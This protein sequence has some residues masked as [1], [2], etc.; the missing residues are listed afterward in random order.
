MN[1]ATTRAKQPRTCCWADFSFHFSRF[2][3]ISFHAR[4]VQSTKRLASLSRIL[5]SIN[6]LAIELAS[7]RS[8]SHLVTFFQLWFQLFVET[9]SP[10]K[11]SKM[12]SS[13]AS[14][15]FLYVIE[16]QQEKVALGSFLSFRWGFLIIS[17]YFRHFFP[18]RHNEAE[19]KAL[20]MSEWNAWDAKQ[21]NWKWKVACVVVEVVVTF[22]N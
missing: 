7:S 17:S 21:F 3:S 14:P 5:S 4:F 2:S 20:I 22:F 9:M 1:D 19:K 8:E 12:N 16:S 10:S 18:S 15:H 13:R 6:R 11:S